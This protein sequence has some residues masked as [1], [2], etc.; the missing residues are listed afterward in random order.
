MGNTRDHISDDEICQQY[1]VNYTSN[2][3]DSKFR[4]ETYI[5]FI[6]CQL[7]MLPALFSAV[8]HGNHYIRTTSH[9][10]LHVC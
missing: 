9:S 4:K 2:I 8:T 10:V 1:K 6:Y 7:P 3:G 5:F